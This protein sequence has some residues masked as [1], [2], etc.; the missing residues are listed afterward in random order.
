MDQNTSASKNSSG[1]KVVLKERKNFMA[2]AFDKDDVLKKRE[3][4]A[5]SLRKQKTK[6]IIEQKRRKLASAVGQS[7]LV[8]AASAN[9]EASMTATAVQ[10]YQGLPEWRAS[11]Y[12]GQADI[13]RRVFT[14]LFSQSYDAFVASNSPLEQ[15]TGLVQILEQNNSKL[16]TIENLALLTKVRQ[17]LSREP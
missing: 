1:E 7:L 16:Q 12:Q 4:F 5:V 2:E 9:Q 10:P 8:S 17:E 13:L 14:Q 6:G 11:D 15:I 3:E